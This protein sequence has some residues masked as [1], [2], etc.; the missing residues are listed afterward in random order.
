MN[1]PENL[2]KTKYVLSEYIDRIDISNENIQVTFKV[3]MP[4][5]NGGIS[6]SPTFRHTE[7][8]RRKSLFKN[9]KNSD[10]KH[11]NIEK[12]QNFYENPHESEFLLKSITRKS[13][14]CIYNR[15]FGG[16]GE[17]SRTPV[18]KMFAKTFSERSRCF[19]SPSPHRPTTG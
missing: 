7:F 13:H 17:E 12:L 11:R 5:V 9:E 8:I 14:D 3:T 16:G 10:K 1:N 6:D 4:P 19:K 15:D 2:V 18:R